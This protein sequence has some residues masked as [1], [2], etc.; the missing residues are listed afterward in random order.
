M[1]TVTNLGYPR[2]G[3]QRKLKRALE[4][5]WNDKS[6]EEDLLEAGRA[7]RAGRWAV[8]HARGIVHI[9][10][11][12]FSLYDHVLDTSVM[13]GRSLAASVGEADCSTSPRTSRWLAAGRA[14]RHRRS[15]CR[16]WR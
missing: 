16:L 13:V 10:S 1:A 4:S 8:Q 12:D 3:P 6:S 7:L 14:S 5:F 11:N 15:T 2:I 9:P